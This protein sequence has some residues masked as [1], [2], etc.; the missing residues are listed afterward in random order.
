MSHDLVQQYRHWFDYEKDAHRKVLE[1]FETVPA[2]GRQSATFQKALDLMG[3]IIV[4][5][6]IWLYRLGFNPDR[7]AQI[8]PTGIS[9]E[10]LAR[11]LEGMERLWEDYLRKLDAAELDRVLRYQSLDAGWFESRL[12]DI[13]A[14][15]F[16]HS[17][18][19]RGQIASLVKASGGEPAM[20]DYIY[21]SRKSIPAP[22]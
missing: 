3:H 5:R 12:V 1:S 13:L 4:A 18:Y 14:Q 17:W 9:M 2:D 8:F 7:P 11:D 19:H 21:W 15:L 22:L 16:G 10:E 6:R 20:T